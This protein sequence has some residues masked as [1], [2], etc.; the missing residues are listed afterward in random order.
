MGRKNS[1]SMREDERI[2]KGWQKPLVKRSDT[3]NAFVKR[4]TV[5]LT[6]PINEE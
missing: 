5:K 2:R 1:K 6:E 4:M 3:N